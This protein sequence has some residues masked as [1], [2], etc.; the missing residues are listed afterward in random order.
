MGGRDFVAWIT[1]Q[2]TD[3][4]GRGRAYA[5]YNKRYGAKFGELPIN[6]RRLVRVPLKGAHAKES[7]RDGS[8]RTPGRAETENV[9]L[10][11]MMTW[12]RSPAPLRTCRHLKQLFNHY[13]RLLR[14]MVEGKPMPD[15]CGVNHGRG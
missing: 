15:L 3:H 13:T 12:H 11:I 10:I 8:W 9:P 6:Y 7:L 2:L 1:A 14:A 4:L 5:A